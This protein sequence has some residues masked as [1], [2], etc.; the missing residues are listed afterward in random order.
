MKCQTPPNQDEIL[1]NILGVT[2]AGEIAISEFEG[3]LKAE[4]LLTEKLSTRT[5]FN[6]SYILNIHKLSLGHLYAFAGKY[7]NV[8]ISKIGFPFAAAKYLPETMKSFEEEMLN[9]IPNKYM[10]LDMLISDVARV[11]GELLVVHPFREGNGRTARVL[12]NLMCRKQGYGP[13]LFEKIGKRNLNFMFQQ[14]RHQQEKITKR[15][16]NLSVLFSQVSLYFF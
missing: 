7:R 11:H 16:K 14:F 3:F 6:L 4:I 13:L 2:T 10:D 8:N 1:P 9:N 15:W 12:A 5:K